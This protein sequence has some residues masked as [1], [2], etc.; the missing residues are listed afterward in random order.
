MDNMTAQL[1][2]QRILI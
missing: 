2:A 1:K